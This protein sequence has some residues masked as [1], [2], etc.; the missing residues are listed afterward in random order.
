LETEIAVKAPLAGDRFIGRRLEL[1]ALG[2]ALRTAGEGSGSLVVV[3]GEAG[4]G[5]TRTVA[6]FARAARRGGA[7]VL[8]GTCYEGGATR[9]YGPW[10][11]ALGDYLGAQE[12]AQV[13]ELLGQHGPVL[14]ELVPAIRLVLTDA[15]GLERLT[16]GEARARLYEAVVC[17]VDSMPGV[18][19][20]VIDDMQWADADVQELLTHVARHARGLLIVVTF[21]GRELD[22]DQPLA[23]RLAEISRHLLSTYLL[24]QS[25]SR[26]E[27]A[28]LLE[29][30]TGETL[31]ASLIDAIYR[32]SNGNPFFLGELGRHLNRTGLRAIGS[33]AGSWQLPETVRQAVALRLAGLSAHA[34]TLL[35][36]ASVFTAGFAFA[37][38]E[39]LSHIDGESMLDSLDEALAAELIRPVRADRYDFAHCLVRHVIYDCVNPSRRTRLHRRL[40]E[41][42]ELTLANSPEYEAELARQYRASASL[43]GAER[44]V[45]HAL[46]AAQHARAVHAPLEAVA[47]LELAREIATAAD[48]P[49]RAEIE[50]KL[51][52]AQAEAEL[53]EQAPRTLE[54][55]LSLLQATGASGE[56]VAEVVFTVLSSLHNAFAYPTALHESLID[57]GLAALGETGTLNWARL[58]LL[59]RPIQPVS[60]G[61][62]QA[63]RWC[64]LD[65]TAVR[66]ARTQGSEND[67]ARTLDPHEPW[68]ANDQDLQEVVSLV[69]T[70]RLPAARVRGMAVELM[71]L[72]VQSG[73]AP[74][75]A[76]RVS[77]ELEE[78]AVEISSLVGQA[79]ANAFF[80][81]IMG[82][83]GQFAAGLAAIAKA[84]KIAADMPSASA[85]FAFTYID[86]VA[87]LTEM[88]IDDDW[89]RRSEGMRRLALTGKTWW[90]FLYAALAAQGFARAGMGSDA[91]ELLGYVVPVLVADEPLTYTQNGRVAF[92]AEAAWQLR[93]AEFAEQLLPAAIALVDAEA[94]DWYMTS[95]ELTAARLATV[96]GR[97]EH[98][99]EYFDRARAK[100]TQRGQRPLSAIVDYDQAL[101]RRASHESGA[102]E[103]LAVAQT[104]FVE[105]GMHSWS[106]QTPAERG[107]SR[108]RPD[109]LTDREAQVLALLSGG[110]TNKEIAADLVVSVHTVERH[111]QNAYRKIGVRNRADAAAYVVR[112]DL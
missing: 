20:L 89:V 10:V 107:R 52:I 84:R 71:Y 94:G 68:P 63:M 45:P 8:W 24:L 14:A 80:A 101:A 50:T 61:P 74:L 25:L 47:L 86:L 22:L 12:P 87:E 1:E 90:R 44:G 88:Q 110:R 46:A 16:P 83:R 21:R 36:Y 30:L 106:G 82:A 104:R 17:L 95:N 32:E 112:A 40:A 23:A 100:L 49:T 55:A 96:L 73:R 92:A 53:L 81:A 85:G 41:V 99:N 109:G 76:E 13:R 7:A 77:L 60:S 66:I 93:D 79:F 35:D 51:A 31:E 15:D 3:H 72:T 27:S 75:L 59:Q 57:W 43:P 91:R 54:S 4:I 11:E 62:I 108:G 48:T 64:R 78:L 28:E 70:W 34:R 5:K 33:T 37:E 42:L 6:E 111:L 58:K 38:L 103:L 9:P 65:S 29:Y 19:I 2:V 39:L 98:A 97:F 102:A 56:T 105:L 67:Y 69:S 26:D 18:P